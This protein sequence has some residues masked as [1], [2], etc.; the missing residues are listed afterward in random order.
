M[1]DKLKPCPFCNGKAFSYYIKPHKHGLVGMPDYNGGGFVECSS[2]GVA[3]SGET[4]EQAK[5]KWNRRADN[6]R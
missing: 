1:S 3:L 6:D 4:E 2:C 5:E